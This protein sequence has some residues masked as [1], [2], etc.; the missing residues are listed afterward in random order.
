MSTITSVNIESV[1]L[2][3]YGEGEVG[4]LSYT[5]YLPVGLFYC[6][7]RALWDMVWKSKGTLL[8]YLTV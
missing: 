2:V 1:E 7:E 4:E 8:T 6:E 3:S 5:G